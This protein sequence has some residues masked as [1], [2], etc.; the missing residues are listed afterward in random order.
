MQFRAI[1]GS[2]RYPLALLVVALMAAAG[3]CA[4]ENTPNAIGPYG[5]FKNAGVHEV[6]RREYRVDPPDEIVVKA[7]DIKELDG[8][9]Q[10]VRPDGKVSLEI[11][12]EVLVA[13][14]TPVE[15]ADELTKIASRLY[16][17]PDI[18]VEVV[19]NSKFY[20]V[21]GNGVEKRGK[22]P[23]T[24]RVTLISAV[25]DA[26][27]SLDAWPQQVRLSRPGR[28]GDPNATVVVDFTK[29][30]SYGDMN[31][32]YLIEDGDV[33]EIPFNPLSQISFDLTR[34][35]GPFTGSAAL[36]TAPFSTAQTVRQAGNR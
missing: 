33:I 9:R 23:Y 13:G 31:Q 18:R 35:I 19:A 21:F 2:S 24:G 5:V 36:V 4:R 14:K 22:Y 1:A 10:V 25:A 34:L 11:I 29:L 20:Y 6:T 15:I 7:P 28:D 8:A 17:K 27:Y 26:G 16:V 3:G 12:G 30:T 32:N